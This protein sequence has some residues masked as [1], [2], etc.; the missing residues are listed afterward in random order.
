MAML[1]DTLNS[2]LD[3]IRNGRFEQA[4]AG[5]DLLL[6]ERPENPDGWHLKGLSHHLRGDQEA[7]VREISKAIRFAKT[8]TPDMLTNR[9][10]QRTFDWENGA[11]RSTTCGASGTTIPR[12]F[13]H[14][15]T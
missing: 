8:P 11:K 12:I 7:A 9:A 2:I 3:D 15:S 4:D 10:R 6:A 13:R 5:C 14:V 1:I